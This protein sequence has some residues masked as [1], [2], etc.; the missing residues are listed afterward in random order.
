MEIG[1]LIERDPIRG[2]RVAE[3]MSAVPAMVSSLE[4]VKHFPTDGRVADDGVRVGLPM[5]VGGWPHHGF[6]AVGGDGEVLGDLA[7]V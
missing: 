4:Q 1:V 3:N 2:M 7:E 6:Q 5:V